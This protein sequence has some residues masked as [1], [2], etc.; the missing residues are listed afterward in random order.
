M[1]ADKAALSALLRRIADL[2]IAVILVEHDMTL[3]MGISDHVVVLDAGAIIAAGTPAQVRRDPAVLKAYLGGGEMRARPRAKPWSGSDEPIL[4]WR[5]EAH[6][7]ATAPRR[8]SS[9]VTLRGAARRDWSRCSAPTAPASP[10]PCARSPACCGRST[11][12]S[13]SADRRIDDVS[14]RTGSPRAGL[15][16]VPEGRQVFPE[17]TR[18]ATISC[19]APMHGADAD[20]GASMRGAAGAL[21]ALARA[22]ASRAGL[23][24]G[25][26]QQMLAIARGLMAKPRI[27]LLDEPSLGL[28]P[29][30]INELFDILADLR[31]EGVTILLVDQMA[32][33]ALTVAD[34]GYVLE[35]GAI[36]RDGRCRCA[37]ARIRHWKPPISA[38]PKPRSRLVHGARS[39]PAQRAHRRT[40]RRDCR[41]RHRRRPDR[42]DRSRNLAADAP[43]SEQLGGRLVI[44][45]LRRDPHPSRQVLHPR[46]LP[47]GARHAGG[48]DRAKSPRPSAAFT[49]DDVYARG[50]PHAGKGDRRRA[51]RA[52]AR[53]SRSIRASG[54]AAS[55]PFAASSATMPGRSIWRSACFR[56]RACSTIPAPR[57][58]WSQACEAGADLIGGCPYTDSDPARPDRAHFRAS[59]GASTSTSIFISISISMPH[60]W[61]SMRSAGRRRD[62]AMAAASPVGHVTKLSALAA[63]ALAQAVARGSPTP[64][65]RVTVLPATDLFL[66]GRDHNHS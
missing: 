44:A 64:A 35:S 5:A 6:A 66:M 25:G 1:R 10:R 65:S 40:R 57:S 32:A 62:I 59:R 39:H 48:G 13:C 19:S 45:G 47:I 56:R 11:A 9:D 61:I 18:Y 36:V 7:P 54:C 41:H 30:M 22:P 16:L 21:S 26:E 49:E 17:L 53:M 43:S 33:L 23:L 42:R 38:G 37:C 24:S 28:A 2:G 29:A 31:D 58:C 34:R 27:L 8:C 3:V 46:S 4:S 50:T 52:C 20:H 55:K 60:G 51:R 15:S 14:R 63:G 12:R